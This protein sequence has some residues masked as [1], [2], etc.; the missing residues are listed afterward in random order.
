MYILLVS[1]TKLGIIMVTTK[2]FMSG[3][4]QAVRIPK[5]FQINADEVE[6]FR[7]DNEIVLRKKSENLMEAFDILASMPDDFF[8]EA[9]D[10]CLPQ[11]REPL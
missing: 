11:E 10:D 6:I 7:R 8:T 9:R 4:S 5:E 3:N 1:T 2:V